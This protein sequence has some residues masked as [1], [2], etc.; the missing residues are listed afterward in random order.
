MPD[1]RVLD[2]IPASL[3]RIV[4]LARHRLLMLDYDGTIAPFAAARSQARPLPES[5]EL[6]RRIAD[7]GHTTVAIVSGRPLGEL[8]SLVGPLPATFVG[9]HGWEQRAPNGKMLR[10]SVERSVSRALDQAERLARA[11]GWSE[12]IERKR[13]AIV[14]HTRALPEADAHALQLECGSAWESIARS[15]K[16]T[17]DR[18]DG[19]LELRARGRNKGTAVLS[20]ISQAGPGTLGVFV[21]D[22][23]TDEDAFEVVREYGFGVRVGDVGV[24]SIA[25]G[26]LPSASALPSF[27]EEWLRLTL[28]E[29]C[30][31]TD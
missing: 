7:S 20:L 23:V 4:A 16:L 21:G 1:P 17:L 31:F 8:E 11:A 29:A 24:P 19:G 22:D 9:E 28:E 13:S 3:W 5:I 18:I 6:V 2:G 27:L 10:H 25:Q 15:P 26:R 12:W 14:L 30:P